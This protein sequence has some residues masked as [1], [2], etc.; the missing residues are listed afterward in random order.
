VKGEKYQEKILAF[1]S[2]QSQPTDIEKVKTSCKIGN[3]NTAKAHCLQLLAQGKIQG[4]KTSKGWVFWIQQQK[5]ELKPWEEAVATF[6]DLQTTDENVTLKLSTKKE[7]II[8]YPKNSKEAETITQTLTNIPKGT[9]IAILATD[10]PEKPLLVRIFNKYSCKNTLR[11]IPKNNHEKPRNLTEET[12]S[13][14]D[15]KFE[16]KKQ[17]PKIYPDHPGSRSL[18]GTFS[19][20]GALTLKIGIFRLV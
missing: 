1:L 16:Q 13:K 18:I 8:S 2:Q 9:K 5:T 11:N 15:P 12:R 6:E 10:I 20:F 14:N 4:Q 19:L 17:V 7:I 3:W